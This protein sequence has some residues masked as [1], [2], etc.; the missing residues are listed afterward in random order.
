MLC[1]VVAKHRLVCLMLWLVVRQS[2]VMS[3]E[4]TVCT[5]RLSDV[6]FIHISAESDSAELD[7]S[8]LQAIDF[9]T[10]LVGKRVS[11]GIP[12]HNTG[13]VPM[14]CTV[15]CSLPLSLATPKAVTVPA[16]ATVNA[17]VQWVPTGQCVSSCRLC[18][19]G[20]WPDPQRN[21]HCVAASISMKR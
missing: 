2:G 13:T 12:L 3:D 21:S 10:V 1:C 16:N 18:R 14:H 9:G 11:R 7:I 20:T 19:V 8:K 6:Q 4:L 5:E 17:F 15:T